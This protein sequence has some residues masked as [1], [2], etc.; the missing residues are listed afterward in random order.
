VEE[1]NT[2]GIREE[3]NGQHDIRRGI[4]AD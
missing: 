4:E 2:I 1:A 3:I